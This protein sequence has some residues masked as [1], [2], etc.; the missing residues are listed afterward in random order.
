MALRRLNAKSVLPT[1]E[2]LTTEALNVL[3]QGTELPDEWN[4]AAGEMYVHFLPIGFSS[5]TV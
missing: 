2:N 5:R 3:P 4:D 1:V